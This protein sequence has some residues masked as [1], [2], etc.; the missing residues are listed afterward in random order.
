MLCNPGI[1]FSGH[2]FS[3]GQFL[4]MPSGTW[5]SISTLKFV[6]QWECHLTLVQSVLHGMLL[7]CRAFRVCARVLG[8]EWKGKQ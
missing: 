7:G 2:P 8:I 6:Q 1:G 4:Q 5:P 3:W